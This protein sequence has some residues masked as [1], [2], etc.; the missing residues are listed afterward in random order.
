MEPKPENLYKLSKERKVIR[1]ILENEKNEM[2]VSTQ[3][4]FKE[5]LETIDGQIKSW[6]IADEGGL[7]KAKER[8]Q[9]ERSKY[10][11]DELSASIDEEQITT[12]VPEYSRIK[13]LHKSASQLK[14]LEMRLQLETKAR[15]SEK[16]VFRRLFA[17]ARYD[18][19]EVRTEL[20]ELEKDKPQAIQATKLVEYKLGMHQEGHIA[21]TDSVVRDLDQIG[22]RFF[23]GKP[24]FLHGPTG[25]GKTS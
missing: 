8:L 18:R 7:S 23:T 16:E 4:H 10:E 24:I 1:S 11:S 15:P 21:L 22:Q 3:E 20:D 5:E 6:H 12:E 14:D 9:A 17:R 2:P 13:S 25:T 19:R